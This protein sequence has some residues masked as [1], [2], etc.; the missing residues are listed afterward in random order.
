[1]VPTVAFGNRPLRRGYPLR[2]TRKRTPDGFSFTLS[3]PSVRP[4]FTESKVFTN[5]RKELI[6]NGMGSFLEFVT[7][8]GANR[9]FEP[10]ERTDRALRAMQEGERVAAVEKIE[11]VNSAM[12]FSDTATGQ[13]QIN[14]TLKTKIFFS[15]SISLRGLG[16][17]E[18]IIILL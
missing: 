11:Q 3:F 4:K 10:G 18:K 2:S 15:F 14:C 9:R 1:L 12:I 16:R 17:G 5:S 7:F 6:P 13:R 8:R